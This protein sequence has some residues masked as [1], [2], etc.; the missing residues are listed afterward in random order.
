MNEGALGNKTKQTCPGA[1]RGQIINTWAPA[2]LLG[3]PAVA[4]KGSTLSL[5]W[6]LSSQQWE[7]ATFIQGLPSRNQV[8][9][10]IYSMGSCTRSVVRPRGA[11][12]LL[13][14]EKPASRGSLDSQLPWGWAQHST[15]VQ[16][17]S[18]LLCPSCAFSLY[19]LA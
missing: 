12:L 16:R 4:A 5:A 13:G 8:P 6:L 11:V 19:K 7:A 14:S 2:W 3:F 17:G 1:P 18:S 9:G 10:G 15:A